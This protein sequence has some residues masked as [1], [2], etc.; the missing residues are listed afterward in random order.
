M[1]GAQYL[2]SLENCGVS[3]HFNIPHFPTQNLSHGEVKTTQA[4]MHMLWVYKPAQMID[5]FLDPGEIFAQFCNR[6]ELAWLQILFPDENSSD[7][8]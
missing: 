8:H 4:C 2:P 1:Q 3:C 5:Y 7:L 6:S